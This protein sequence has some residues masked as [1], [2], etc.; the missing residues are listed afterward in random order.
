[1]TIKHKAAMARVQELK[2]INAAA[3]CASIWHYETHGLMPSVSR[4]KITNDDVWSTGYMSS[5]LLVLRP[6][7]QPRCDAALD[8]PAV[9][10][11]VLDADASALVHVTDEH[12]SELPPYTAAPLFTPV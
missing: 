1:M 7:E 10:A 5:L 2:R 6:R 4:T 8:A 3:G 11:A 12:E 9:E